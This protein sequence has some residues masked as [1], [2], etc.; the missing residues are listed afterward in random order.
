MAKTILEVE[1][2]S[3]RYDIRQEI[4]TLQ[5][6]NFSVN[7][8]E[9]VAIIGHNGSGKS[10]LAKLLVG[11]FIPEKGRICIA[12]IEMNELT[13]WEIRRHIGLIFQNPENQFIGTT[14][15]D[16][17]AFALEN[18]NLSYEEMSLR[19]DEALQ[20]VGI[21]NLRLFDPSRLSGGQKQRVAIAGILALKPDILLLDEALVMLDP[22]SRRELISTL[23]QI[24]SK[25]NTSIISITHDMNEVAEAD[26]ILVMKEGRVVNRGTPK[27][28]FSNN[29]MK[30]E[31]PIVEQLRRE[32]IKHG[33]KMPDKYMTEKELVKYLWK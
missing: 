5:D 9:W 24:K 25:D 1:N 33:K 18:I 28:V 12:D 14:V 3:F 8:G 17:V 13:K 7:R 30:F 22:R 15:Q 27:Q 6:V 26:Y 16:D 2:L 32:L 11:L 23:K 4:E 20:T 31:Y 21:S 19:I 10:T 29:T